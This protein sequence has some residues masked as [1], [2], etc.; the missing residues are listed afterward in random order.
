MTDQAPSSPGLKPRAFGWLSA[1]RAERQASRARDR[2]VAAAVDKVVEGT[3]RRIRGVGGYQRKLA[4]AVRRTLDFVEDLVA[5]LPGPLELS[6][7]AWQDDS[8]VNAFFG[9]TDD[10]RKT[11]TR[12]KELRDFFQREGTSQ[13]YALLT[14]TREE[15]NILGMSLQ[16]E[17]VQ[18]E[19][20]QTSVSFIEHRILAPAAT[21]V[22]LREELKARALNVFIAH[23]AD[24][25]VDLQVRRE[26]LE[27]ERQI[28]QL[29][30]RLA[31][32]REESLAAVQEGSPELEALEKSVGENARA[33]EALGGELGT[34]DDYVEQLKA[35]FEQPEEHLGMATVAFRVSRMGIKLDEGAVEPGNDLTLLELSLG[36]LRRVATLVRCPREEM[37]SLEQFLGQVNPYLASQ[38]G[39]RARDPE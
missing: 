2:A 35:V 29:R 38:M 4:P 11:L 13:A 3:D 23:A 18:R 21:E 34:L 22:G 10:V 1:W 20:P 16:G 30:L 8:H 28:L 24:R 32:T 17:T 5:R 36:S 9:T 19:V 26:G 14:M 33:L 7:S 25:L 15:K 27:R 6:R 39:I 31:R 12:S 37:L